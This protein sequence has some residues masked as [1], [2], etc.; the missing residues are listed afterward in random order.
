MDQEAKKFWESEE[1]VN[2]FAARD[3][4][5]R[6][7]ELLN[8]YSSPSQTDVL[9]IGCAG[10]RN[11]VLLAKLG[12]SF[13]ALDASF[14]M[15][16]KT[17]ER[18]SKFLDSSKVNERVLHL[19]M[20]D[21]SCFKDQQ[22]DLIIALGIFHNAISGKEWNL[23]LSESSRILKVGGQMLVSNFSSASRPEG[24]PLVRD[25]NEPNVYT[26]FGHGKM[27]L[28]EGDALDRDFAAY[29][30]QPVTPTATVHVKT[31]NGER[32]TINALYKKIKHS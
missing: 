15:V 26:G 7:V 17:R 20:H 6:L 5:H 24:I 27:Y 2:R 22:F 32:V 9:D 10:G 19:P 13:F 1:Q 23:T 16:Q 14:G 4:D 25:K 31:E 3:P 30:M 11:A 21:L 29:H 18:L 12:F 8:Q 28:I